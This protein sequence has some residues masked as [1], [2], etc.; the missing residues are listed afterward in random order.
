MYR[1]ISKLR[2]G[3]YLVLGIDRPIEEKE[4]NRY[5]ING[6]EYDIVPVYDLPKSI[7]IETSQDIE[8]E[9]VNVVYR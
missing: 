4:Y 3:K 7:A 1:I 8:A 2:V 6:L 5:I 9:E